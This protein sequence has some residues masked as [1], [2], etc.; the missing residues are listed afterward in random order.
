MLLAALRRKS[1]VMFD[2]GATGVRAAQVQRGAGGFVARTLGLEADAAAGA[3]LDEN[4]ELVANRIARLMQQSPFQGSSAGLVLGSDWHSFHLLKVPAALWDQGPSRI[5]ETLAWEI[6]REYRIEPE[7]I[8]VG[9][10]PL[11]A[12]HREGLNA[13]AAYVSRPLAERLRAACE[14]VGVQ[15]DFLVPGPCAAARYCRDRWGFTDGEISAVVQI[16]HTA[17]TI[18]SLVGA[19]PVYVRSLPTGAGAWTTRLRESL[20]VSDSAAQEMLRTHGFQARHRPLRQTPG[21]AQRLDP[22]DLRRAL[23]TLLADSL[24]SLSENL[25]LCVRY[26]EENYAQS[27][28]RRVCLAGRCAATPGLADYLREAVQTD[29]VCVG[30]DH[31]NTHDAAAYAAV[32]GAMLAFEERSP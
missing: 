14:S 15:L 19:T 16:G 10:W 9:F 28:L 17:T 1:C 3:R 26:V 32:G 7:S 27:E 11:P 25:R 18:T 4:A 13:M 22:L 6:S 31:R 29:V 8:E 2:M 30:I 20:K 21:E 24:R 12:R 5:Q 23:H